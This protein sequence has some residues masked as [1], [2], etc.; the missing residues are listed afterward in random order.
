MEDVR[1]G[2]TAEGLNCICIRMVF[3]AR[4]S[5]RGLGRAP[6]PHRVRA[7]LP[8]Y[9]ARAPAVGGRRPPRPLSFAS[10]NARAGNVDRRQL[11]EIVPHPPSDKCEHLRIVVG[12]M[13]VD[14]DIVRRNWIR[15]TYKNYPNV[16]H[17]EKNPTGSFLVLFIVGQ[18]PN[19]S[20]N[21]G[22]C[23][24]VLM[25]VD[26]WDVMGKGRRRGWHPH[27]T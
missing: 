2:Y 16:Y 12:V 26:G 15:E 11:L 10:C 20:K 5:R 8:G 27:R 13:S 6:H 17:W 14:K 9:G 3:V 22:A 7:F 23:T 19:N 1:K 18:P 21:A 25:V 4:Y 24:A